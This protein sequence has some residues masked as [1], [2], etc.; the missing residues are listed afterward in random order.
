MSNKQK[1]KTSAAVKTSVETSAV[2]KVSQEMDKIHKKTVKSKGCLFIYIF[3]I[4]CS[5]LLK[6]TV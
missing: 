2:E 5:D 1:Q 6:K 3:L 4:S